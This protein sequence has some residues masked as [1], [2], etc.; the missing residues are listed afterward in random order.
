[1][2]CEVALFKSNVQC[3]ILRN[4][5]DRCEPMIVKRIVVD[6]IET[7][8]PEVGSLTALNVKRTRAREQFALFEE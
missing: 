3:R 1:M 2:I 5:K 8:Y 6:K 7:L 4:Y